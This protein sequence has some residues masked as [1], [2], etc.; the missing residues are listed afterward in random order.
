MVRS[1]QPNEAFA[2]VGEINGVEFK[3]LRHHNLSSV[4]DGNEH[5]TVD[6][7]LLKL[8]C[9]M[10]KYAPV[11]EAEK[12]QIFIHLNTHAAKLELEE[13]WDEEAKRRLANLSNPSEAEVP[14]T[15][16]DLNRTEDALSDDNLAASPSIP[17][18]KEPNLGRP[19][20]KSISEK[21]IF[22]DQED[23]PVPANI[24]IEPGLPGELPTK[25]PN[26]IVKEEVVEHKQGESIAEKVQVAMVGDKIGVVRK[27]EHDVVT[28]QFSDGSTITL[29]DEDQYVVLAELTMEIEDIFRF[30]PTIGVA[31]Y[32]GDKDESATSDKFFI[33]P[34][35]ITEDG[36]ESIINL[37]KKAFAGQVKCEYLGTTKIGQK[38]Y[39]LVKLGEE[40]YPFEVMLEV[41]RDGEGKVINIKIWNESLPV[42][43][44]KDFADFLKKLVNGKE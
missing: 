22:I 36:K 9:Q 5:D 40:E 7:G 21:K 30:N 2:Y 42:E 37:L 3:M 24:P 14:I 35:D 31:T 12:D 41:F 39:V 25:D 27:D 11:S 20:G 8:A 43:I 29:T 38:D 28:A 4:K 17:K 23:K 34:D 44:L 10:V 13:I 18:G 15:N 32:T 6:T 1:E 33:S 19:N 16:Q 26:A